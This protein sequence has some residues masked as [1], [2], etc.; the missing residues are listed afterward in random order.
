MSGHAYQP[1]KAREATEKFH[2]MG[3]KVT[4]HLDTSSLNWGASTAREFAAEW[5]S[6]GI[7]YNMIFT[8][9]KIDFMVWSHQKWKQ[10][11][12]IDGV[13]FDTGT[14]RPNY[15]TISGTAYFLPDGRLQPGWK[16]SQRSVRRKSTRKTG[17]NG[18][19]TPKRRFREFLYFTLPTPGLR[20]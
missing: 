4:P 3:L 17:R 16:K 15:N 7:Q 6:G 13:Y 19:P 11:Y 9:S 12:G 1:E 8:R 10:Q 5:S 20:Q 18:R 2:A 14:P